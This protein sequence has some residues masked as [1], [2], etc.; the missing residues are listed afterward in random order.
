MIPPIET[1]FDRFLRPLAASASHESMVSTALSTAAAGARRGPLD[2]VA[3]GWEALS[4]RGLVPDDWARGGLPLDPRFPLSIVG[5]EAVA[6]AEAP[7]RAALELAQQFADV[8][9]LPGA[10]PPAVLAAA[11]GAAAENAVPWLRYAEPHARGF[12]AL[13]DLLGA[14]RA[15]LGDREEP[16][17]YLAASRTAAGRD[18]DY[19]L[20]NRHLS[21]VNNALAWARCAE[22]G[23]R[24][25]AGA[26]A[27]VG[28]PGELL[29]GEPNPFLPIVEVLALGF[30]WYLTPLPNGQPALV[31]LVPEPSLTQRVRARR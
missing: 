16:P 19:G 14:V 20:F 17:G 8:L 15:Q 30:G 27:A 12:A 29:A 31:V 11:V 7:L 9:A 5:L 18:L 6:R 4:S 25:P 13:I 23:A 3:L 28:R 26:P 21:V 22:L 10:A 1:I 2:A 24:F